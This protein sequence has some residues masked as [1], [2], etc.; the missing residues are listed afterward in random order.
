MVLYFKNNFWLLFINFCKSNL[1][2]YWIMGCGSFLVCFDFVMISIDFKTDKT[3]RHLHLKGNIFKEVFNNLS[4]KEIIEIVIMKIFQKLCLFTFSFLKNLKACCVYLFHHFPVI[5]NHLSDLPFF[6]CKSSTIQ[7]WREKHLSKN[8][9]VCKEVEVDGQCKGQIWFQL[10]T[11]KL[12]FAID[13]ISTC[14]SAFN[15]QFFVRTKVLCRNWPILPY[16]LM[17]ILVQKY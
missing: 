9:N 7:K 17:Y 11:F 16:F 8:S 10:T 5:G 4:F 6:L 2:T 3:V 15:F 14:Q 13:H 1:N 12:F